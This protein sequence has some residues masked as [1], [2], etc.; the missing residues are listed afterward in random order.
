MSKSYSKTKKIM[1]IRRPIHPLDAKEYSS[2]RLKQEFLMTDLMENDKLNLVYTHHDRM[3]AGGVVP[4]TGEIKLET[5][6]QLKSDFFLERREL[7]IINIGGV[8]TVKVDQET[9]SLENTDCLYIGKGKKDIRFTSK[10]PKNA[11]RFYLI[12]TLAHTS[13]PIQ[14]SS[15]EEATLENLGSGKACNERSIYKFIHPDGIKSCQ[16]VMGFTILKEGSI[17]NTMPAHTHDRRSEIYFYFN[18]SENDRVFHFMGEPDDTRHIVVSNEQGIISPSW[19]IHA[20]AGT[21]PYIFIWAMAG[22]NQSFADMDFVAM[23]EIN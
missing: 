8:G 3:I 5:T 7:G 15:K 19:S 6:D 14:K 2:Q 22:E 12:S 23:N 4:V 10:D 1:E 17:W 20:G 13:Y 9:Y 16:L 21:G 18:M 11:A